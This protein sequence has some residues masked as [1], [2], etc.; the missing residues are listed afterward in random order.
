MQPLPPFN[1]FLTDTFSGIWQALDTC[2]TDGK[3]S[4][5][6]NSLATVQFIQNLFR[7]ELISN[8]LQFHL[9]YDP[10]MSVRFSVLMHMEFNSKTLAAIVLATQDVQQ[11]IR[12]LGK[13]SCH[14][15]DVFLT[16]G[17]IVYLAYTRIASNTNVTDF[18]AKERLILLSRAMFNDQKYKNGN[19]L[20]TLINGW[21]NKLTDTDLVIFLKHLNIQANE[22]SIEKILN[23]YFHHLV[24]SKKEEDPCTPFQI[25]AMSFKSCYL[26][27]ESD[28]PNL[29]PEVLFLWR[30][31]C[32]FAHNEH[33]PFE[34]EPTSDPESSLMN[35]PKLVDHLV[36]SLTLFGTFIN[37]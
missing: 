25:K 11:S 31:F 17:I 22:D 15:Q 30:L 10:E 4:I 33:L 23:A 7:V 29:T 36:P 9:Q 8:K 1:H 21:L 37:K 2:T 24:I 14:S 5:R 13:C 26:D 35:G 12:L 3:A 19:S 34:L 28:Q 6:V 18:E 32:Q 20:P 16:R 27:V